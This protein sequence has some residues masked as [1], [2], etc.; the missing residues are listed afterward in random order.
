MSKRQYNE[1]W[2]AEKKAA[3]RALQKAER[4]V[5]AAAAEQGVNT[6]EHRAAR[7]HRDAAWAVWAGA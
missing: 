5:R 4:A 7:A 2:T 6:A 1:G 3:D